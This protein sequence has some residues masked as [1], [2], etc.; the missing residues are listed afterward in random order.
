MIFNQQPPAA[1]GGGVATRSIAASGQKTFY[2]DSSMT[3][4]EGVTVS[5]VQAPEGSIVVCTGV[6][7]PGAPESGVTQLYSSSRT[8]VRVYK[9]NSS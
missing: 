6:A 2:T 8:A 9:V 3:A 7:E 1:G 4:Q 5:G